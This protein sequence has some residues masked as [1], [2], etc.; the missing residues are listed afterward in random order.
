[1]ANSNDK[2]IPIGKRIRDVINP[3]LED[4][5]REQVQLN[6]LDNVFSQFADALP[7]IVERDFQ[8]FF[9]QVA[10][11]DSQPQTRNP[12]IIKYLTAIK[13]EDEDS[14]Y[15]PMKRLAIPVSTNFTTF[16]ADEIKELPGYIKLHT[17][18]RD[19]DIALKIPGL[20]AD[21]KGNQAVLTF[22]ASKTYNQGAYEN[23]QMY[24][25]LPPPK[26]EFDRK[27]SQEFKFG[28]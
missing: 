22:D 5:R 25:Q 12:T 2:S 1:M 23:A 9:N 18:A 13:G 26:V 27:Q 24:P 8:A 15:S 6:I 19:M 3:A 17:V 14:A 21:D 4:S 28:S 20:T 16:S 10:R 7:K 11:T